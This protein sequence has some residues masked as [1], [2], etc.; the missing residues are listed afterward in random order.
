MTCGRPRTG[1]ISTRSFLIVQIMACFKSPIYRDRRVGAGPDLGLCRAP[2]L[3]GVAWGEGW[4]MLPSRKDMLGRMH[5]PERPMAN[6][7]TSL[8]GTSVYVPLNNTWGKTR[9]ENDAM[10]ATARCNFAGYSDSSTTTNSTREI[11]SRQNK[12]IIVRPFFSRSGPP[13]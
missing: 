9:G 6:K 7:R 2:T 12:R 11:L 5:A 13:C 10:W 8:M 1:L 3:V 4:W